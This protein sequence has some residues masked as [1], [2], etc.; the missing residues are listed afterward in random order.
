MSEKNAYIDALEQRIAALEMNDMASIT[1]TTKRYDIPDVEAQKERSKNSSSD[2]IRDAIIGFADGLTV[3]FALTAGL[4]SIGSSKL[5][6]VGGMAE[7]FAGAISMGLGA[8]L[9]AVT[10]EKEFEVNEK[11]EKRSIRAKPAAGEEEIYE[12][13]DE[14]DIPRTSLMPLADHLIQNFDLWIKFMMDFKLKME[15]PD[16]SKAWISAGVMGASYFLGGII[17]MVPYFIAKNVF[18]ALKISIAIAVITLIAFGYIKS[19][20]TGTGHK[21]AV[22]S[23]I[24]TLIVGA[25]AVGAS[26]GIVRG[27]NAALGGA[28]PV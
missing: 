2:F 19:L 18:T 7:L 15:K 11:R 21:S 16:P 5:V 25:L 8:W 26:Y 14:Y 22:I 3:P 23:A 20:I 10:D 27:V 28:G 17:P 6:I 4:S 9:A 24:Q 12:V 13:F 1:S